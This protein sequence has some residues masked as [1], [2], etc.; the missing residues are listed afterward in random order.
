MNEVK[1]LGNSYMVVLSHL[2]RKNGL[3]ISYSY[4]ETTLG[5]GTIDEIKILMELGCSYN[6]LPNK[7]YR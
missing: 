6:F 4:P 3:L 5:K 2:H 7:R 1:N